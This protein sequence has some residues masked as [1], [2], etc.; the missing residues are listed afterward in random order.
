MKKIK[1]KVVHSQ[2]KSAWNVV[3]IDL[4]YKYKIARIPYFYDISD[5][6]TYI[7]KEEAKEHADFI[8]K[9]FNEYKGEKSK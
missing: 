6:T 4:G 1:T 5:K 7:N 3:S 8:S 2:T 9:S